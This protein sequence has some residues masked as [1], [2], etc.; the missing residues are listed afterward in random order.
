MANIIGRPPKILNPEEIA[1]L[2]GRGFTVEFVAHYLGVAT[3]TL[4][5]NYSDAM[6]KGRAFRDGCL[7]AT[8]YSQAAQ[9]NTTMLIWLGKQWLR[10]R[11]PQEPKT[12]PAAMTKPQNSLTESDRAEA[13]AIA[14][15]LLE[16]IEV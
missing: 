10:Q 11:E 16:V 2:I 7:Q 13:I 12:D 15:K 5:L 6:R 8:Q 1:S 3:S 4:Y 9:G 14:K